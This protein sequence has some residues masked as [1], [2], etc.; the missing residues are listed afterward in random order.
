MTGA[1]INVASNPYAGQN[2]YINQLVQ[3]AQGDVTR[4]YSNTVAPN[5]MA[6]F[7]ASGAYGGTAHQAA[8]GESQRQLADQ[9]GQVS[10]SLRG[11]DYQNQQQLAEADINRRTQAQSED[12]SRNAGLYEALYGRQQDAWNSY[13][14]RQLQALALAP[15]TQQSGYY[16]ANMLANIGGAQQGLNQ[17]IL[18]QNYANFLEGRDWGPN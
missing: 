15:Q 4:A 17:S 3:D 12:L 10:T 2:P 13:Q 1:A 6:Q 18:D 11:A 7:N 8:L 9:L 5:L 16:D 14:G